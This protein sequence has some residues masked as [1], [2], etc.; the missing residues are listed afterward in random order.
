M[1]IIL[2]EFRVPVIK[3]IEIL[4][5]TLRPMINTPERREIIKVMRFIHVYTAVCL[6]LDL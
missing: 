4:S 6:S 1:T 5:P 2:S 3:P